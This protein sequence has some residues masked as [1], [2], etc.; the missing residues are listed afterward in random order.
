VEEI[1]TKV[2]EIKEERGGMKRLKNK[3]SSCS[4]YS[5]LHND[6]GLNR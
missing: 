5:R 1:E 2:D 3:E 4:K 6:V